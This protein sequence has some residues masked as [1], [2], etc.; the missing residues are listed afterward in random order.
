MRADTTSSNQVVSL[1]LGALDFVF[2]KL[3]NVLIGM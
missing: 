2:G 3:R 1:Y